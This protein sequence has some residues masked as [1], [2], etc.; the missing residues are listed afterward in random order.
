VRAFDIIPA[1]GQSQNAGQDSAGPSLVDII[2]TFH[3]SGIFFGFSAVMAMT[4]YQAFLCTHSRPDQDVASCHQNRSICH[5]AT[6]T[7]ETFSTAEI[8]SVIPV[9]ISSLMIASIK[10]FFS[11]IVEIAVQENA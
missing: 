11:V 3:R 2:Q 5:T 6:W 4:F 8:T 1:L 10:C 9:A 7:L